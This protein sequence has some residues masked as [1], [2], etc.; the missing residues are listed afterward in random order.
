MPFRSFDTASRAGSLRLLR[1]LLAVSVAMPLVLFAGIGWREQR[2]ATAEAGRSSRKTAL[3]LHEH[4]LKVFDTMA[5][6]LGRVDERTRGMAWTEIATSE[7][8][9]RYLKTL[10]E[11]LDQIGVIG[12]TDPQGIIQ[13]SSIL[14]PSRRTSIEG[15][16]YFRTQRE[17]DAGFLIGESIISHASGFR[18]FGISRRRTSADGGF[19]GI[20]HAT[21]EPDYFISFYRR[22]LTAK[23]E[24]V[25]LVRSDGQVLLR[26][27]TYDNDRPV[28]LP[29]NRGL[30]QAVLTEPDEG[31]FTGTGYSDGVE[32]FYAYKKVGAFPIYVVYAVDAS[33]VA[34]AWWRNM[35]L[36]AAFVAPATLALA[37]LAWLAYSRARS[38]SAALERWSEEV[39]NRQRLED[40]L[41]Q[42]QK[43][44][45]LGQ[46]TGGVAHDFN[47]LLTAALTNLH[48]LARHLPDEARRYLTGANT[49]LERAEKLTRQLLS[50]S[51][52]DA[53]NPSVV[54][55]GGSLRDMAD[56]LERS[57]RADIAL[58]WDI[59]PIPL[60]IAVDPVQLE[61]A[62]LN[63]VLNARDAMPGGGRIR[64]SVQPGPEP[65]QARIEVA[66]SGAGMTPDVQ[67]RAFEPFFTTKDTGKGTGL[68]LSMVYGFVRQSGGTATIDSRPG[69]GTRVRLDFPLSDRPAAPPPPPAEAVAADP[70]QPLRVLM[71]EDNALV[72][73]AM[74]EGLSQEGFQVE[75]AEHGAAALEFLEQDSAFDVVISDVVMP[76]GVS[77][78][79]LARRIRER[80]PHLCV[81]LASGYSPESLAT[82]G[83]GT[84]TVLAKPFTPDQLAARVRAILATAAVTTAS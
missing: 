54:E 19:D 5:Q 42:S 47:N 55:L 21:V 84:A 38:E 33:V 37:L 32:R 6:V 30:R 40:A 51:R 3:V 56:L 28:T 53:I 66:D 73:L 43:M 80:W 63:L 65:G 79:D 11:E 8:L 58:D 25:S 22:V 31:V 29:P 50:F 24:T 60:A 71:V 18:T 57:I 59:A 82:M 4:V 75:T 39:R 70:Q 44:E 74:V 36:D 14:F 62:I 48:L 61:L 68:G 83:A 78:I 67:A 76:Y 69:E 10:D 23:G 17:R 81:L 35:A 15:R 52:Q 41:R 34:T 27:P 9:H 45:A 2:E 20:I 12:V 26:Y 49:A 72:L 46:L 7:P 16:A 77:G 64:L 1:L 13:S